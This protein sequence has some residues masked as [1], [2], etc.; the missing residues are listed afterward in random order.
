[1]IRDVQREMAK[2]ERTYTAHEVLL[3]VEL[4]RAGAVLLNCLENLRCVNVC[5]SH[6]APINR[7]P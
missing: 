6:Q 3:E 2:Q 5:T 7:I 4:A 1:M